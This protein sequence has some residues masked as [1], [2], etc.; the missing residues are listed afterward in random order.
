MPTIFQLLKDLIQNKNQ[1]EKKIN[2]S[3]IYE[4]QCS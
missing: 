4:S 2:V 3:E 1:K